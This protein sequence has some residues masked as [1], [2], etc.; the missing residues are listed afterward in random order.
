MKELQSGLDAWRYITSS[1]S[2]RS[3]VEMYLPLILSASGALGVLPFLVLRFIQQEWVAAA[4]D[5]AIVISFV[6]LGWYVFRTRRVRMASIALSFLCMTGVIATVY[7]VGP[8]QVYWVYPALMAVFYLL[9]PR[10]A[11]GFTVLAVIVLLPKLLESTDTHGTTTVLIT[12]AVMSAFGFAFSL[13]TN[14]QRE[15]LVQLATKDPLTGAGNRRSLDDKLEEIVN[16][17]RR[18]ATAASMLMIDLDHF[19][20]VNDVHGHAAG[21]RILQRITE[22]LNLRIRVTDSLYRIGGEE[23]VVILEGQGIERATHL[24]EQLR[25]LVEANELATDHSVTISLGVAE[26]NVEEEAQDWLQRADK[27]LYCAKRDGRN[28]TSV[29]N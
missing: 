20:K 14:W 26:L 24:A 5:T 2:R 23:F 18:N 12:L 1:D 11:I 15:R 8:H 6:T 27:A 9:R 7:L 4:V 17:Y 10:E 13:I 3:S 22:I 19:K 25:T 21:D 29:A 28:S 16:T